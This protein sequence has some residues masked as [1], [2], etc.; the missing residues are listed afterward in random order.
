MKIAL[1]YIALFVFLMVAPSAVAQRSVRVAYVDLDEVLASLPAY[2]QAQKNLE[3]RV[4]DWKKEAQA[5]EEVI[6]GL[7]QVLAQERPLLTPELIQ[8]RETEINAATQELMQYRQQRFGPEGDL[9]IARKGMME[10]IQDQVYEAIRKLGAEKGYDFI[11]EKSSD[12]VMLYA[13]KRYDL[14]DELIR[15]LS[16]AQL[17]EE[18]SLSDQV[19][20]DRIKAPEPTEAQEQRI[21][22]EQEK[23]TLRT[24]ALEAKNEA[25]NQVLL[26]K[27]QQ[28]DSIRAAR[29]AQFEANKQKM[30]EA[31]KARSQTSAKKKDTIQ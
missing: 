20:N 27:K 1:G 3:A 2:A 25:K 28:Q 15:Q 21:A 9:M 6:A 10:P 4:E 17:K 7:K 8:D 11:F 18:Y 22:A 24:Q 5:R 23:E 29:V 16:K 14:S 26:T 13:Q 19:I 30:L 31:R 12:A